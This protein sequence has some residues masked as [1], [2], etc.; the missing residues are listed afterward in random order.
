MNEQ[1]FMSKNDYEW[2]TSL[3][4]ERDLATH[5]LGQMAADRTSN[6]NHPKLG[7]QRVITSTVIE[8][9]KDD[10]IPEI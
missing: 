7:T 9:K 6:V 1:D 3:A 2:Y 8:V 4:F 10:S 5:Q